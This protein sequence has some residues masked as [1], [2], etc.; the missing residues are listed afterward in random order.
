MGEKR[1][2][3]K[4]LVEQAADAA[5]RK[6]LQLQQ[7]GA[8]QDYYRAV[9]RLLRS[10]PQLKRLAEH[11]EL[12]GFERPE[13][14]HD[15]IVA[16]PRGASVIDKSTMAE[17]YAE[18]RARSLEKTLARFAELDAVVKLFESRQGFIVIRM[19]YF[20]EDE[21]GAYRGD[22][23]GRLTWAEI[24]ERLETTGYDWSERSCRYRRSELLQEMTVCLFGQEGALSLE[25]SAAKGRKAKAAQGEEQTEE[26]E[27]IAS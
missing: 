3:A 6:V 27:G 26:D 22:D 7:D 4:Q 13:H 8:K 10:Y 19:Y 2:S 9:E 23:A 11:P 17:R 5:A 21:H 12:Y 25:T 1:I 16:P 18:A 15:V 14:S 20:G 24:S